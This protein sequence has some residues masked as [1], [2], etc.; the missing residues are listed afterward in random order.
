[1]IGKHIHLRYTK[2]PH[3]VEI[4]KVVSY[5][6]FKIPTVIARCSGA[7]N[8]VCTLIHSKHGCLLCVYLFTDIILSLYIPYFIF[9]VSKPCCPNNISL[10][11]V[12]IPNQ[13][14]GVMS[15][16]N[17]GGTDPLTSLRK[18]SVGQTTKLNGSSFTFA[19][20]YQESTILHS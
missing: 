2:P 7:P 3:Y 15:T 4:T 9:I 10:R 1:V 5:F 16:P 6:L 8:K 18:G 14:T 17:A 11:N 20:G 13:T 19:V 12:K